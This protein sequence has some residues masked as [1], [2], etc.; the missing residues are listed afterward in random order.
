MSEKVRHW[1]R[2]Y[3]HDHQGRDT[4]SALLLALLCAGEK[5]DD[6]A[7]REMADELAARTQVRRED[8]I[9]RLVGKWWH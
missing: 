9:Y 1:K 3:Q 5:V 4:Q 2:G 6:K 8:R 7:L